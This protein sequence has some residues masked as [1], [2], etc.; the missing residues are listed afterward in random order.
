MDQASAQT[1]AS[2]SDS[3]VALTFIAVSALFCIGQRV[4]ILVNPDDPSEY[5]SAKEG[6]NLIYTAF[7]VMGIAFL[8]ITAVLI[9]YANPNFLGLF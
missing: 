5:Y 3:R 8:V 1:L 6:F 7:L 9:Y 2:G 4:E